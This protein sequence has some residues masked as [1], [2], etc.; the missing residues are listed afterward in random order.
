MEKKRLLYGC[1][2]LFA[3]AVLL[4]FCLI[5]PDRLTQNKAKEHKSMETTSFSETPYVH[6]LEVQTM[7]EDI[8][9]KTA[10]YNQS[11]L[12]DGQASS[13]FEYKARLDGKDETLQLY[14][15]NKG[16]KNLN[17]RLSSPLKNNWIEDSVPPGSIYVSEMQWGL[18]QEGNWKI[19]FDNS[20]GSSIST[21][22]AL[23]KSK[24]RGDP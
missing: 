7:P 20:D 8:V 6:T 21:E 9:L 13:L 2:L 3:G 24:K 19:K 18:S 22:F 12:A 16:L 5:P 4:A 23:I 14:V 10:V 1:L 11:I 15:Y 17:V